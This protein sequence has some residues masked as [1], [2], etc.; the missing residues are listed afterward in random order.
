PLLLDVLPNVYFGPV[1]ER[2]H[3]HRLTGIEATVENVPKFRTLVFGIPLSECV[4]EREDTLL[5]PGLFLI[6]ACTAN[7][8]INAVKFQRV[9]KGFR[10]QLATTFFGAKHERVCTFSQGLPIRIHQ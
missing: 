6:T 2:K 9:E 10:L 1:G 8:S 4:A 3:A 7:G 5:R